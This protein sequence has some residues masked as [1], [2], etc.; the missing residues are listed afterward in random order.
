MPCPRG[1]NNT[2]VMRSACGLVPLSTP[3]TGGN[4]DVEEVIGFE[5]L[6]NSMNKCIKGVLWKDGV[7]A[8][9]HNWIREILRLERELHDG[10]YTERKPKFFTITEPKRREIMSIAFRDRVYQRS[11]NDVAIYPATTR[12]FIYDN[13][14]CQKGKGTKKAR[15]R[16]KCHLQRYYRKH[17]ANGFVLQCDIKGYY[18]NMSHD[19]AKE[20]LRKYLDDNIYQMAAAILDNFPGEVGFNPGSQIVQIVGI[21]A[22]NEMDHKIKEWYR[23]KEYERYMDDFVM[24]DPSKEKLETVKECIEEHLKTKKMQLSPEKTKIY[25]IRKGIKYLG[26]IFKLT[27]TGKV[28]VLIDPKKVKHERKKLYRMVSQAKKGLKTR[29]QID[30]HFRDWMEHV[31]YGDTYKVRKRMEEYYAKLWEDDEDGD[32]IQKGKDADSGTERNGTAAGTGSEPGGSPGI[33]DDH[34]GH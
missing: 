13:M 9:Y 22:L 18:P 30:E 25:D 1:L 29:E 2:V 19:V 6:Y 10:S 11:L 17:G 12:T 24:L 27:D 31:S 21:T 8:F 4:V 20:V 28:V 15:D 32:G 3:R 16:L 26:F 7:A 23:M 14:A 33:C 34:G 5:A